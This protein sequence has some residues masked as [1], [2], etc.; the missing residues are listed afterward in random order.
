MKLWLNG[1]QVDSALARIDP[2]DRGYLLGDGVFETIAV[3]SGVPHYLPAHL[4]RLRDDCAVLRLAFPAFDFAAIIRDVMNA[5]HLTD[6]VLRITISRGAGARGILPTKNTIETVLVTASPMPP[7]PPPARCIIA[8]VTRRNEFSPL[9]RVKSVNYLDSI[10]ARQ[11]ALDRGGDEA[12]LL[13]TV[14][15]VAE[16]TTS[17][18]FIVR[19]GKVMTPPVSDGALPGIMRAEVLRMTKGVEHSLLLNDILGADEVFLTNSLGIRRVVE[20]EE[21][22][23]DKF[24]A[25]F[26]QLLLGIKGK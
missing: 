10:L 14:G 9:S 23:S 5:N 25:T 16:A 12:I 17:N 6:A 11:E 19:D 7:A 8:T 1:A 18:I 24:S 13:N 15:R 22:P 26:E 4:D 2:S 3:R 20:I 21:Q